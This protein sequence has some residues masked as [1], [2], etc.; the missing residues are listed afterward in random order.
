MIIVH[1][2]V[3]ED[4]SVHAPDPGA[5]VIWIWVGLAA[6]DVIGVTDESSPLLGRRIALQHLS[7]C[8]PQRLSDESVGTSRTTEDTHIAPIETISNSHY[9]VGEESNERR[10]RGQ[11]PPQNAQGRFL[12]VLADRG[13]TR[14]GL[15]ICD[16]LLRIPSFVAFGRR[17]KL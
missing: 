17:V 15:T 9:A 8:P 10:K 14:E 1:E 6:L 4:H 2:E 3:R 13:S 5:V 12:E 7:V 11:V 16:C